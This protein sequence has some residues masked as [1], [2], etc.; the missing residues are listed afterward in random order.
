MNE[1]SVPELSRH[2]EV[3][4]ADLAQFDPKDSVPWTLARLFNE[5]LKQ[6]KLELGTNP[7]AQAIGGLKP[8]PDVEL[9][10]DAS[11]ASVATVRGLISQLRVSL[12][13]QADGSGG[14]RQPRGA[15]LGANG[16]DDARGAGDAMHS[17]DF[18]DFGGS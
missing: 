10:P 1:I 2:L 17:G 18:E 14:F 8:H 6:S 7:L 11:N 9:N 3:L 5:M 4:S 12:E 15:D 13:S 16:E